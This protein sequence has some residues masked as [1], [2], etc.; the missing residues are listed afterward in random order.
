MTTSSLRKPQRMRRRDGGFT[1]IELM[2]VVA[3]IGILT[4]IALPSYQEYVLRGHRAEGRTALL[5]ASQWLERAATASG[6][7]PAAAD[8]PAA[9]NSVPG[10]R[11]AISYAINAGNYTLTATPNTAQAADKCGTLTLTNNGTKT[12]SGTGATVEQCWSR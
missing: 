7:Y 2:I 8:F 1:L 3:V 11:Y 9:L 10:G 6:T 12:V 4:A 5:Q